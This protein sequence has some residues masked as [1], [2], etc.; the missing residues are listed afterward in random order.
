MAVMISSQ[1]RSGT[2]Y[3]QGSTW[4]GAGVNFSLFSAHATR[5]ELCLFD[6]TGAIEVERIELPEFTN[7]IWHGYLE[8][9]HPG[10]V[11]GYRVHGPYQ[12]EAGHRFNPNKL[13]L[14]PFARAYVGALE[15]NDACFGYTVGA[16]GGDL[17]FDTRDSASF[18]PKSVVTESCLDGL[19]GGRCSV[20]WEE[21][22]IYELHVGGYTRRR[23]D[24]PEPHRGTFAG[25]GSRPT[26]DYIKSLGVT[27]VELM[28]VHLFVNDR[29]LVDR[30][31]TNYWGYNSIGFFAPDPRYMADPAHGVREFREM[32]A[33]FHDAGLEVILDVVYNHTAEGSELGPTLSFRGID[34]ASY[35]RLVPDNPRYYNNDAGTGNTLN[36]RHPRVTQMITDSLRYWVVEM[37]VDGFRFDLGTTLAR[38]QECFDDHSAFLIACIQDPTLASVKLIAEPWDCGPGGYQAGRFPPGWAEWNDKFRDA[39]R[40]FWRGAAPAGVLS[41]RLCASADM[42]DHRGRKPWAS[43]NFVTAHDGFTLHDLVSYDGKHNDANGDGNTDGS[44]DNRSSNHGVEGIADDPAVVALRQQQMRNMLATLL[45]AQG[46]PMILA[47][48][49]FGRTQDGNNNA[50]CQDNEISW[51]DWESA[52]R[53]QASIDFVRRLTALRRELPLLRRDRFLTGEVAGA[54]GIKDVTWLVAEGTEITQEQWEDPRLQSFGML[55]GDDSSACLIVMNAGPERVSWTMPAPRGGAWTVRVATSRPAETEPMEL[56]ESTVEVPPRSFMLLVECYR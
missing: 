20:P 25:L 36:L 26:I 1:V 10:T 24:L 43:I 18:V 9:L 22:I 16:E 42:F 8:G 47:G 53:Q 28:P 40:D 48:D 46:T 5:V 12:P 21:A 30:G 13:L 35:Y 39:V 56:I 44:P 37:D 41:P 33:R 32:V 11:Y 50:Y 14:D 38:P 54:T 15:W 52:R 27:S 2:P 34:N 51:V 7:E 55:L 19:A 4:D 49:E 31:L 6:A 17:S 3:P 23:F 29:H 45:C